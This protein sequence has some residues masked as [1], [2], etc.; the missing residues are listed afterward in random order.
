M[1]DACWSIGL[2]FL[3]DMP[4]YSLH[5]LWLCM[6]GEQWKRCFGVRGSVIAQT[7]GLTGSMKFFFP[8]GFNACAQKLGCGETCEWGGGSISGVQS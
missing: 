7:R 3:A 8:L 2:G 6:L 1:Q 4:C 5:Y